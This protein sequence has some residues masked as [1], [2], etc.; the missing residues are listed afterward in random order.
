MGPPIKSEDRR[1]NVKASNISVML[2]LK[3]V[4]KEE[5]LGASMMIK[6]ITKLTFI[7]K[8]PKVLLEIFHFNLSY[9]DKS[10]PISLVCKALTCWGFTGPQASQNA[11]TLLTKC[12]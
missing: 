10:V 5:E 2:H 11:D 12:C 8:E 4:E 3:G 7:S 6:M 1:F 9:M